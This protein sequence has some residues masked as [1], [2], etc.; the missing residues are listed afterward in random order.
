MSYL[1]NTHRFIPILTI[2]NSIATV[3]WWFCKCSV[4]SLL[5]EVLPVTTV[6]TPLM[7]ITPRMGLW[8]STVNSTVFKR[9][10]WTEG[11]VCIL[12][13]PRSTAQH[14]D[15]SIIFVFEHWWR[16]QKVKLM[17]L[18][19]QTFKGPRVIPHS[20]FCV[21]IHTHLNNLQT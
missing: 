20:S 13:N 9:S 12:F 10:E 6:K 15:Y 5:C 11:S 19:N 14:L 8:A 7:L 18:T 16:P 4:Q 1:F 17:D 3:Q 2:S 21:Q